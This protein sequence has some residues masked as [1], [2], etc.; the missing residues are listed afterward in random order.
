MVESAEMCEWVRFIRSRL[1]CCAYYQAIWE[2]NVR[3]LLAGFATRTSSTS[4]ALI[5]NKHPSF[6]CCRDAQ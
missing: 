3:K 2:P 6:A 4:A 5:H 1:K